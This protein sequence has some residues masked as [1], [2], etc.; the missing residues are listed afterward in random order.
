[1]ILLFVANEE[2]GSCSVRSSY[3]RAQLWYLSR[4]LVLLVFVVPGLWRRYD[5]RTPE[6]FYLLCQ[7]CHVHTNKNQSTHTHTYSHQSLV[8]K[9]LD[10]VLSDEELE[11]CVDCAPNSDYIYARSN[12][13]THTSRRGW[14]SLIL[15]VEEEEE[16]NGN[17]ETA[18]VARKSLSSKMVHFMTTS[19][20][21]S[22]FRYHNHRYDDHHHHPR[23]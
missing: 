21:R 20:V 9:H 4:R 18:V 22:V 3:L 8:S 16:S 12:T 14:R 11:G 7:P 23:Q 13:H 17:V 15:V 2:E 19:T 5:S 1:M 6:N 10:R